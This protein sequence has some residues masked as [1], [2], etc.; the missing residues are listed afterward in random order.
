MNLKKLFILLPILYCFA[1][2][3]SCDNNYDVDEHSKWGSFT[4]EKTYSQD[5]VYYAVQSV[6]QKNDIDFVSVDIYKAQNNKNIY[7]FY[8]AR[9]SDFWGICWESKTYNIW[10][11]SADVGVL[12][13]EFSDESWVLNKD[14]VRPVEIVSKYD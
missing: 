10:I 6:I 2:F 14:A 12:C 7:S 4:A 3:S 1:V 5:G 9:A 8:P 11:Q 13:Y